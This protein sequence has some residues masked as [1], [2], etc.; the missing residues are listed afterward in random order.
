MKVLLQIIQ[1]VLCI[2]SIIIVIAILALAK[3]QK[4]NLLKWSAFT[5]VILVIISRILNLVYLFFST[6]TL[7]ILTIALAV[8]E[9]VIYVFLGIG[10]LKLQKAYGKLAK[11]LGILYLA[12]SGLVFS[13]IG[14]IFY[15][16]LSLAIS[17]VELIFFLRLAKFTRK[18]HVGLAIWILLLV[19]LSVFT[20][21]LVFNNYSAEKI[22]IEEKNK[23]NYDGV[24]LGYYSEYYGDCIRKEDNQYS[25]SDII[26][27]SPE[28]VSGFNSTKE[29]LYYISITRKIFD[30]DGKLVNYN[31]FPLGDEGPVFLEDGL[32]N[33]FFSKSLGDFSKGE[34]VFQIQISD[35]L[36][37]KKVTIEAPF[38]VLESKNDLDVH[39]RLGY[40]DNFICRPISNDEISN[41]NDLCFVSYATNLQQTQN[42][43]Y[44]LDYDVKIFDENNKLVYYDTNVLQEAEG[45]YGLF[46]GIADYNIISLGDDFGNGNYTFFLTFYDKVSNK[47]SVLEKHFQITNREPYFLS[48]GMITDVMYEGDVKTYTI[49]GID[50]ETSLIKV[51]DEEAAFRVNN[52]RTGPLQPGEEFKSNEVTVGV[53][54]IRVDMP[55]VKKWVWFY[56]SDEK[57]AD[58]QQFIVPESEDLGINFTFSIGDENDLLLKDFIHDNETKTYLIDGK[59]YEVTLV[60]IDDGEVIFSVNGMKSEKTIVGDLAKIEYGRDSSQNI[61]IRTLPDPWVSYQK[62]K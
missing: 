34:Y 16:F 31:K 25:S 42:S 1:T 20:G 12:E 24:M 59:Y 26:C 51:T 53:M 41:K 58:D 3:K 38:V 13:I 48:K 17:I 5:I 28:N 49:D 6:T 33:Y 32:M 27:I 15:P 44:I 9:L 36:S 54:Q 22:V 60:Y 62:L 21:I 30:S 37:R 14:I 35:D 40:S 50:F 61:I 55:I 11:A 43:T 39:W 57:K 47:K 7:L 56:L 19:L 29:G 18:H 2:T 10:M 4:I 23:L 8:L 45:S 46:P 52:I